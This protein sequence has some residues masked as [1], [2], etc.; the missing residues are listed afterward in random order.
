MLI[1][2]HIR[3]AL[4]APICQDAEQ[5][6]KR[7]DEMN[8]HLMK[9]SSLELLRKQ[10]ALADMEKAVLL[11]EDCSAETGSPAI[12]NDEIARIVELDPDFFVGLASVDPRR[13][14]ASQ[15]L[16]RAF[17]ELKLSGLKINTARLRMYPWDERLLPLY[18][19]CRA[20]RKPIVFHAGLC[21]E[22]NALAKYAHPMEFEEVAMAYPDINICLAHFGWPWV[23]E[24]AALLIKYP[25]LYANTA[26]V[27]F[28]GPYQL[29]QKVFKQDMGEY[30]LDHN[31]ADK[32]MF[33]SGSPRIRPVRSKRGMDALDLNA[34]T[35]EKI[36]R[37]NAIRFFGLEEDV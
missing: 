16:I 7:C 30:W 28:D 32:V 14:D 18:E 1:D 15:E 8:F 21:M 22:N 31:L 4:F 13:E 20:Y 24:T 36:Y 27:N 25:N 33:G 37:L 11:P 35:R 23:Q 9:P 26:M 34:D 29:F 19:I 17:V 2:T 6:R 3:P 12:S 10:Y 5:F